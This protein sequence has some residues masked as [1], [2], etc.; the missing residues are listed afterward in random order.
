MGR[1]QAATRRRFA[2]APRR[3]VRRLGAPTLVIA[4]GCYLL[5][6]AEG[7][8]SPPDLVTTGGALAYTENDPATAI[9]PGLT[10]TDLDGD[11][12]ITNASV[13][14]TAGYVA[15]EDVL[16]FTNQ[17]GITGVWNA[18]AGVLTL[19]GS[20]TVA[21]YETALRSVTYR[22]TSD[23]PDTTTRTVTFVITDGELETNSAT[24]D[25]TVTAVDDPLTVSTTAG[26][27]AY[28]E[29]A[30]ALAVDTGLTVTDLDDDVTGATVQITGNYQ[31]GEDE[32]SFT[33]QLGIT[34]SWNPV[35][36]TLT[37][38][39][40]AIASDYQTA[41][42][43]VAYTNTSENPS[44]LPR[45]VTVTVTSSTTDSAV[46]VVGITAV[47]D[48]PSPGGATTVTDPGGG[49]ANVLEDAVPSAA[50]IRLAPPTLSDVD[51]GAPTQVR[52]LSVTGGTVAQADGSAIGLGAGGSLLTLAGG[53]V[54][55]RFT[56]A[57]DRDIAATFDYVVVDAGNSNLNSSSSTATVPIVPVNDAPTATASAGTV[58]YTENDPPAAVDAGITLADVDDSVL[59]GATVQ[60]TGNYE[61][62]E[63]ELSFTDQLGITGSWDSGTGTLTLSGNAPL[64]DYQTALRSVAYENTS[65]DPSPALR[66][67]SFTVDDG[68][69]P[70]VAA[71]R[72]IA[73]TPANDAPTVVT[74]SGAASYTENDVAVVVDA[75][76]TVTDVDSAN[77]VGATVQISGNYAAREDLLSFV[78][79]AGIIGSWNAGTGTLT[80]AGVAAV[81]DY[82]AALRSIT[83]VNSS[84]DPS[85]ASRTISISVTDGTDPSTAGTRGIGVASVNDPPALTGSG[86]TVSYTEN[87]SPV[88][89]DDALTIADL[90]DA[91]LTGA[92]VALAGYW[93]GEDQ[94]AFTDQLGITG[95]WNPVTGTLTLSG[96]ASVADYET[97]LRSVTYVDTS[98]APQ[99]AA[100]TATIT[101]DDGTDPSNAVSRAIVVV[102]VNDLPVVTLSGSAVTF[103]EDDAPVALD[104][105]ATV[106]DDDDASLVGGRVQITSGYVPGQDVLAA[107]DG[108]GV[109]STWNPATGSLTLNG[110]ASPATYETILRGVT[111][112]N[113]SQ[114]PAAGSR[115]VTVT[116]DDPGGTGGAATRTIT[117]VSVNDAPVAHDDTAATRQ[118]TPVV[119]DV[120]ANDTDAEDDALTVSAATVSGSN[121]T[122]S[123]TSAQNLRVVPKQSFSGTLTVTYTVDDGA[124]TDDATLQV[125]VTPVADLSTTMRAWPPY[126]YAGNDVT[127]EIVV[128]NAGPGTARSPVVDVDT[129]GLPYTS[130][131]TA[132]GTCVPIAA[133]A[134]CRLPDIVDDNRG[135]VSVAVRPAVAGP[136][137]A[138]AIARSSVLDPDADDNVATA[139]AAVFTPP[140][141]SFPAP[142]DPSPAPRAPSR[143]GVR[144]PAAPPAATASTTTTT[145]TSTSSTSTSTSSSTSTTTTTHVVP[146]PTVPAG[147]SGSREKDSSSPTG[148]VML[149]A[150]LAAAVSA[151]VFALRRVR[152]R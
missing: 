41:L 103:T 116:L 62:A 17:L 133:G 148:A 124:A 93:N 71:A 21:D 52:I 59:A 77:L 6:A 94:L 20:T 105:T 113:S 130:A 136:L 76:L 40:T 95:S 1:E 15:G 127:F 70:S 102:P 38:S 114:E 8:A 45:T 147:A 129:G 56:P 32:L 126:L 18:G 66:T 98:D 96:S 3:R 64:A 141:P 43:A 48:A 47:N 117:V 33:D 83:Y 106:A 80:L 73:V 108:G 86:G 37:L 74:S 26:S 107:T 44:S 23:D 72:S 122:V 139:E 109:T 50:N 97:A 14:I 12:V 35:T 115:T 29:G 150:V 75:G 145:A 81:A 142:S 69:L 92:T 53:S 120:L 138:R 61:I 100:R 85:T 13:G 49:A 144:G 16:A 68:A 11:D 125:T 146:E 51:S 65:D 91:A 42:R 19:S 67:V 152:E 123:V 9:D 134:R 30:G 111:F 55:L 25:V 101:V 104:A 112:V 132:G 27:L 46:R 119:V 110:A 137:T 7:A 88:A 149:L 89:V 79:Q 121:A 90:D 10:I 87:T 2:R 57:P 24:R 4:A 58:V 143:R 151:I 135:L 131:S 28:T 118:A 84:D 78:D 31:S 99:T 36:G 5:M 140:V 34:G 54:D 63:D 39:G 22:N 128:T 82:Q 60:I